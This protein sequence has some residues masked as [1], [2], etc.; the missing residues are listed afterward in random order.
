MPT[1]TGPGH[2]SI[3]TGTTPSVHGI[4]GNNWYDKGQGKM[5]NCVEDSTVIS[6]GG[7]FPKEQKSPKWLLVSGLGDQIKSVTNNKGKSIGISIKDRSAIFPAG[8]LGDAAY[9]FEGGKDGIFISSSYYMKELPNWV[10]EFNAKQIPDFYLSK[11]WETLLPITEYT[12]SVVD[13]SRYEQSIDESTLPIFPYDLPKIKESKGYDLIKTT[14]FGNNL[15]LDFAISA[16]EGEQLGQDENMDLL[17]IGFSSTDYIGHE[18]GPNS[19][20]IEDTY[21]RL[22]QNIAELLSY[23]D[24]NVGKGEYLVFFT[25]DHGVADIPQ[26]RIDNGLEAGYYNSKEIKKEM[27]AVLF[28][29]HGNIVMPSTDIISNYSNFQFFL[30]HDLIDSTGLSA[31]DICNTIIEISQKMPGV[32]TAILGRDLKKGISTEGINNK[33]QN[34]WNSQRSGDVALIMKPGWLSVYYETHGG[35]SHGSPWAYD[36]H[37]PLLFYGFGI[38][39]GYTNEITWVEDIVPTV[40]AII[41]VQPPMGSTGIVIDDVL[42]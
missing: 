4:I 11:K 38:E 42:E 9:W 32:D 37:V 31:E 40:A 33:V 21:L 25:S 39:S 16:I 20:E 10:N 12:E 7:D 26:E 36:T 24:K 6:I 2:A 27:D 22:D 19:V 14:P 18:Y 35:T 17:T 1:Y 29:K 5:I 34:G 30:N 23:L 3:F 15:I 41:K 28:F 13:S 8:K